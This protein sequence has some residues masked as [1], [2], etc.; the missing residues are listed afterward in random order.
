MRYYML[1][2][3]SPDFVW[4]EFAVSDEATAWAEA[5]PHLHRPGLPGLP[6]ATSEDR[7][8][9]REELLET[10]AGCDALARWEDTDDA[11]FEAAK[12]VQMAQLLVDERRGDLRLVR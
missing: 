6:E 12:K 10:P 1:T 5:D 9:T 8:M 4:A 3:G 11:V 7:V 2:K